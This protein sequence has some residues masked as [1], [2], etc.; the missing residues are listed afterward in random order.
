VIAIFLNFII[1]PMGGNFLWLD[2]GAKE[3]SHTTGLMCVDTVVH[4]VPS[5]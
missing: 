2:L 4:V 3:S 1:S 5:V